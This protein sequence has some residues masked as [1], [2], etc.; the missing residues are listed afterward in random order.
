MQVHC[1]ILKEYNSVDKGLRAALVPLEDDCDAFAT[2]EFR[3]A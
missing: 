3:S 2:T 1:D